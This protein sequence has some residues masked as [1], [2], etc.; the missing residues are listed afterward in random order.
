M[1]FVV[2]TLS[3]SYTLFWKLC[4]ELFKCVL[5]VL[6]DIIF[7]DEELEKMQQSPTM[8]LAREVGSPP[9]KVQ[10]MKA[11]FFMEQEEDLES[12]KCVCN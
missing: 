12:G 1:L 8:Q 5:K 9:H 11:S 4:A 6:C 3:S 7:S 2:L 10:L